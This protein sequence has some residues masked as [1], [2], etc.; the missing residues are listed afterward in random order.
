M[1]SP[2][3]LEEVPQLKEDDILNKTN[4]LYHLFEVGLVLYAADASLRNLVT[5]LDLAALNDNS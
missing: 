3:S 2:K 4:F 1:A 5:D